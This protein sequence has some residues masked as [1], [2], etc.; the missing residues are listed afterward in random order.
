[1]AHSDTV[2]SPLRWRASAARGRSLAAALTLCVSLGAC[3]VGD[4]GVADPRTA[5]GTRSWGTAPPS[6]TTTPTPT[7]TTTTT[8]PPELPG[9]GRSVFP[10]YR[11][12]GFSGHPGSRALG[13]LGIGELGERAEEIVK[14]G[15]DFADGRK[16]MPVLELIATVVQGQPGRDGKYRTRTSDRVIEEHLA[17]AREVDGI[18]LLNIQ[19]GRADFLD[20]VRAYEK[21]LEEP[22]VGLALDPEWAMGPGEVPMRVFGHTSGKKIDQVARY[23]SKLVEKHDLPEKVLVFHQL[24]PS[25]VRSQEDIR[26]R[27]G[28]VIVK[29][30]DGIGSRAMKE[31]TYGKLTKELPEPVH[32]GFKLFYEEDR[33]FGRLMTPKQVLALDP[34][35]EYVLYE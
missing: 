7:T 25:V 31:D 5:E 6:T 12:V 8:P 15:D 19:P 35:P 30:V 18:L 4:Q 3:A 22:D 21:W 13:R 32:A 23:L 17:A 29:S 24:S 26:D 11:L 28:V 34:Q 33:K 16:V 1:M 10:E 9:G 20:E 14:I 2:P 27:P